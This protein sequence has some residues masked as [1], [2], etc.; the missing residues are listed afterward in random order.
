MATR[1]RL[2]KTLLSGKVCT[3]ATRL[4]R[5]G[6]TVQIRSAGAGAYTN[7]ITTGETSGTQRPGTAPKLCSPM[8]SADTRAEVVVRVTTLAAGA[9]FTVLLVCAPAWANPSANSAGPGGQS[10]AALMPAAWTTKELNFVYQT[11]FTTKYTC[12]GLKDRMGELLAELGAHDIQL[13]N[14]GCPGPGPFPG[15]HI[16]MSVLQ[17]A[18]EWAIGRTVP[19]HW[20]T[21]DLPHSDPVRAAAD[22]ELME[23]IKQK[24]LPLFATRNVDYSA[25]CE[26]KNLVL[27]GTQLKVDVL[28]PQQGL[29]AASAA[30]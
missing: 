10:G 28:V 19:V 6:A 2:S 23:Q 25:R 11:G 29:A 30:R 5:L 27:G 20:K 18:H 9:A 17:P 21:V 22:C 1:L 7:S 12:D 14:Y 4:P 26:K 16:K 13:R 8:I 24:V 15:V 3:D